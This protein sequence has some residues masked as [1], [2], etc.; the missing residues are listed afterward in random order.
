MLAADDDRVRAALDGPP[1]NAPIAAGRRG[2]A[3]GTIACSH[4]IAN[5]YRST[6]VLAPRAFGCR[7]LSVHVSIAK[8]RRYLFPA[9]SRSHRETVS[10]DL[11]PRTTPVVSF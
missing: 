8:R 6:S 11:D 5:R 3:R 10:F 2:A 1:L 4:R 9:C 7:F